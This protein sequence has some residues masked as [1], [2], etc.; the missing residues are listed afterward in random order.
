MFE[1]EACVAFITNQTA[2]K[3]KDSFSDHLSSLGIT[4][5]QWVA[6]Y[7]MS[8][9]EGISQK[10]LGQK[11]NIQGSSVA[12]LIDR[13]ERD[14]YVQRQR[15]RTDRRIIQLLLT[16]KGKEFNQKLI[17]EGEKMSRIF[18]NHISEEEME[19]FL[20]VLKKI[21]KNLEK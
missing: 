1:L 20:N 7:Y 5:V 21:E 18:S 6:L 10:E 17:P 9:Y 19:I 2:K 4:R 13:M 14:G 16:P 15:S 3:L 11:M 12:R 8:K